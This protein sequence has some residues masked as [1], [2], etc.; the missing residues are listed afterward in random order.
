MKLLHNLLSN[1]QTGLI[2]RRKEIDVPR[3]LLNLE[4]LN[5]LYTEG[6]INGFSISTNKPNCFKVFLK[7]VNEKSVIKQLKIVSTASRRVYVTHK[8]LRTDLVFKGLFVISSSENGLV[9]SDN[10]MK[11]SEIT[12]KAGGEVL[13]QIIF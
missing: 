3:T 2:I 10:V 8:K 5:L 1:I 6:F 12:N 11:N 7:Y 9:L 4:V 13:F